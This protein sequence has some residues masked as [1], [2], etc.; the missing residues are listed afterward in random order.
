MSEQSGQRAEPVA[1]PDRDGFYVGYLPMPTGHRRFLVRAVVTLGLGVLA[2]AG[3][4]AWF[5]RDPAPN[6][7]YY[8][9]AKEIRELSGILY[10]E[11]YGVLRVAGENP[12]GPARTL[13]LT[14]GGKRGVADLVAGRDG[15]AVTMRG[16]LRGRSGR[17]VFA[18]DTAFGFV[19]AAL[20]SAT[21][22]RLARPEAQRADAEPVV[23]RGE[24]IDPKCFTGAM[25]PGNGKAH[26][27]CAINCL[28][29]GIPP[30]LATRTPSGHESFYLLLDNRGQP[31]LEPLIPWVGDPVEVRGQVYRQA[32]MMIVRLQPDSIRRL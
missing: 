9:S 28:Q 19:E 29:G 2:L 25:K 27:A 24:I 30:M 12:E 21:R 23:L 18:M 1:E 17:Y 32:D 4:L 15:Q 5:Q 22:A 7:P 20:D 3:A 31:I 13:I 10:S 11:P 26:K 16:V 14:T 8:G 6:A